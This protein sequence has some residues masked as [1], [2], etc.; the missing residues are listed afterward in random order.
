MTVAAGILGERL[1]C[2][3]LLNMKIVV[4]LGNPGQKYAGT[5]HNVGFEVLAELARR[6]QGG[7]SKTRFDAE[8]IEI[9]CR[10]EKMLLV[11]PQTF[12]NLSGRSVQ[13]I[14][15]FYQ[16]A[17]E[18]VLVVCDDLNLPS[19]QLRLRASGSAGGQKGL[20]D[21]LKS[22]GSDA[23]PRLRFG[24]GRPPGQMDPADYVL[25]QFRRDEQESIDVSLQQAADAAEVWANEGMTTAMNRF[26]PPGEAGSKKS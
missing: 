18:N 11:A 6:W 1:Y 4:G 22:L 12:M 19:G 24:I 2:G 15:K 26:N 8:L 17:L 14:V 9:V 20:A 7:R 23:I 10:R 25:S 16:T 5:R 13:Q 21:I 3:V